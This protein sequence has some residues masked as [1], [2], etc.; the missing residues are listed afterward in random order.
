MAANAE[1]HKQC[2]HVG[3]ECAEWTADAGITWTSGWIVLLADADGKLIPL[4]STARPAPADLLGIGAN[5]I[6]SYVADLSGVVVIPQPAAGDVR[7]CVAAN[8]DC[9]TCGPPVAPPGPVICGPGA[10]AAFYAGIVDG[11][12]AGITTCFAP[13]VLPWTLT[14]PEAISL[15]DVASRVVINYPS[16]GP[17]LVGGGWVDNGGGSFTFTPP[18]P[19][20]VGSFDW[21]I[22]PGIALPVS[23]CTTGTGSA[24]GTN[25][26]VDIC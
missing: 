15:A 3:T 1:L 11:G 6:A 23:S 12:V 7:S 4:G 13:D 10:D 8:V 17:V 14:F 26:I 2:L 5:F 21:A 22:T 18:A 25:A 20:W 9:V 16:G 24:T 19:G